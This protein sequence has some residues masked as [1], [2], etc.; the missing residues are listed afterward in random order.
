MDASYRARLAIAIAQ[1]GG[2]HRPQ[3][4]DAQGAGRRSAKVVAR[5][6]SKDPITVPPTMSV[7]RSCD[8][9]APHLRAAVVDGRQVVGI[10][11]NRDLR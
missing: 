2:G 1:E 11:T 4:H 6:V 9:P 7:R 3:E 10:V 5:A 8:P